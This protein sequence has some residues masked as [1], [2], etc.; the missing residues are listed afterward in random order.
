MSK[1]RRKAERRVSA[2]PPPRRL[3]PWYVVA[4]IF[5]A[6]VVVCL[7]YG[8]A[9]RGP[10]VFD[11]PYLPFTA[12]EMANA[13]LLRW[14]GGVR[15]FLMFTF[16]LNFRLSEMQPYSYH[17]VNVLLHF[18][19]GVCA[20]LIVRKLLEKAGERGFTREA[21]A[22][23][24]GLLFLLHPLQTESVA[25]VASRSEALSVMFFYAALA[26]FLWR[27]REAAGW[28][29]AAAVLVLFSAAAL[30]K[31]HTA[32]LPAL[33]LLTDY[34]F[35]PGFSFQGIRRNWRLYGLIAAAGAGALWWVWRI[36]RHADTAGFSV[37]EF[38]WVQYFFTQCRA[39]WLYLRLFF[40]PYGQNIDH[41]FPISRT[42]LDHGAIV[43]LAALAA[44][45]AAALW[46]RRRFPLASYGF[47]AFL[48]LIAPTSSV[49][50][51]LD[52]IAERRMYL[53][54]I[55]LLLVVAEFLRR[56]KTSRGRLVSA[57]AA[58]L[59]VAAALTYNRSQVWGSDLALWQDSAAKSP[60][61]YRPHFQ[62]G[63]VYFTQGRCREALAEYD[64]AGR[65]ATPDYRL[66]ID[67]SAAYECAGNGKEALR[68]LEQAA[69]LSETAHVY[70][71]IG[72]QYLKQGQRG[73]AL[74]ALS[75]AEA[76]D[77]AYEMTYVYRGAVH[78]GQNNLAGAVAEYRRALSLNPSNEM[79]QQGL[80]AVEQKLN[81]NRR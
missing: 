81:A 46:Y 60:H 74:E 4:A 17:L 27:R 31:E 56:W 2:A 58:V 16:W 20:W 10:F 49:V 36:I 75:R 44:L 32:V 26:V 51:I 37:R 42:V 73:A 15:P 13:G 78:V 18:L 6:L 53:P 66:L 40:V 23:F 24:S 57:L 67:W 52:P 55:G 48:L 72:L 80:A 50:P 35:N 22:A 63:F 12:Q 3:S 41:D 8:P 1:A 76:I 45:V 61:K 71:L 70:S 21:I 7:A 34:Y 62:L 47:L 64:Q 77:P 38:T 11:D 69:A 29:T 9:L 30:T 19:T 59:V 54:F 79:A 25:Y 39:I 43:G 14:I 5:G 65:A 33:L 68:K 28:L